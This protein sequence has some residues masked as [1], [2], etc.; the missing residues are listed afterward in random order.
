MSLKMPIDEVRLEKDPDYRFAYLADFIGLTELDRVVI[1]GARSVLEPRLDRMVNTLTGRVMAFEPAARHF[2]G[3][4]GTVDKEGI[5]AHL[6]G[7][8]VRLLTEPGGKGFGGYLDEVGAIHRAHTGSRD[9]D[10]PE[11]Q[12]N[13]LLGF[14]SDQVVRTVIELELPLRQRIRAIRAF[15]KLLWIQNDLMRRHYSG[16]TV[17]R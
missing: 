17:H 15:N 11:V 4:D 2:R 6:R 1:R 8:L 16:S 13:A 12:V 3:A 10:V 7:Y 14:I 9:V 5:T